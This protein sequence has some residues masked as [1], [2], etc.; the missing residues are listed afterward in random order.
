[1]GWWGVDLLHTGQ[2][3]RVR[4]HHLEDVAIARVF[5]FIPDLRGLANNPD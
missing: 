1:L 3:N 2:P 4:H 5:H